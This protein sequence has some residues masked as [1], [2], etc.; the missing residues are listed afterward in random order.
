MEKI[1]L[2][3]PAYNC[4]KQIVRVLNK[5]EEVDEYFNEIIIINDCSKDDTEKNI[6]KNIKNKKKYKLLQ[7]SQNYGLGG[8]HKVAFSYALDNN[9]DYLVVLHGDDQAN[10]NDI[11]PL[12]QKK[13]YKKYDSMLGSRF[14]EE[15][16][17]KGYSNF[18]IFG[19]KIYNNIFSI[20]LKEKVYDLGSGLNMYKVESLRNKYYEKYPDNLVF[21]YVM[22]LATNFYH[23]NV[24]YFPISWIEEDQVSNVKMLSQAIRVLKLLFS[25][26]L[27]KLK[28]MNGDHRENRIKKYTYKK[29]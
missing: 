8:A 3:I 14:M 19:N 27:N 23:Q 11:V 24:G 1:L 13:E 4:E 28:F 10:I 15:S 25:Y 7:N 26:S 21:N 2:F 16:V 6:K 22:I 17:I 18:R 12:L 20:M 5:V 29:L 9:F